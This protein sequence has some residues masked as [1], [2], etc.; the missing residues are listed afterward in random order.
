MILALL[1]VTA[2]LGSSRLRGLRVAGARPD[3][4]PG[5]HRLRHRPAA[6]HLRPAAAR[7][8]HRHRGRRGRRSSRSARPCGSPPTC[9]AR[10]P[11]SSRSASRGWASEDWSAPGSPGCAARRS[12]SRSVR[13]RPAARRSRR[14]CPTSPRSGSPSTPRSSATGAIEGVAGPEA[15][16]NASA[17][18][19][20]VPMLAL[21]LPTNAT[22]AVMLAAFTTYGIQPGPLL[23]ERE[24]QLVW[25]LIASLFIGN[26][27]LLVHQPAAGARCGPS[28]CRSRGP[29]CTPGSCSSR[30]S[31]A[32]S[33]NLQAF[34]LVDP[35][36]A[37]RA[38]LRRCG[39]SASRSCR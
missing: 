36:G 28:C 24:P 33:V 15:A 32:Y 25:A 17:A 23:F 13:C 3:H 21:G 16:N 31:G 37:R 12:A 5:R 14:S 6:A 26:T 22:A 30:R 39:A 35:A 10:P 38:R 18:G 4:R 27:L 19:T 11:T 8:R 9:A 2:V 34:D 1:A 29:T 20:L 7:R